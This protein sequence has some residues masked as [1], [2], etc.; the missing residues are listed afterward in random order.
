M[1]IIW[2]ISWRKVLKS[3]CCE[4][5]ERSAAL[6]AVVLAGNITLIN[7]NWFRL[8]AA[9]AITFIMEVWVSWRLKILK[10]V[11]FVFKPDGRG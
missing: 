3:F 8:R 2:C 10:A 7:L 11:N 4:S 9:A 1:N 5:F 6:Y